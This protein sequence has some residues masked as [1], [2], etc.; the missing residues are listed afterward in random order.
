MSTI[1]LVYY[2]IMLN[3]LWHSCHEKEGDVITIVQTRNGEAGRYTQ[4][5]N[6]A[7]GRTF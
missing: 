7:H 2:L 3:L 1:L 4:D 5:F 6:L